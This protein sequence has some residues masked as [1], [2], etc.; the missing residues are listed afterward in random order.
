MSLIGLAA[1]FVVFK[2]QGID[3]EASTAFSEIK[4]RIVNWSPT[5]IF[6]SKVESKLL[7][8]DKGKELFKK[9]EEWRD[10]SIPLSDGENLRRIA[11]ALLSDESFKSLVL[12]EQT[13]RD[14]HNAYVD[15]A[16]SPFLW[17]VSLCIYS[18]ILLAISLFIHKSYLT[19]ELVFIVIT[20]ILQCVV[21]W[22]IFK[23]AMF[24]L[25]RK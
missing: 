10:H 17:T 23:F 12:K 22:K 5:I 8:I 4:Q 1:V 16:I 25:V 15:Q 3:Q 9:L 11:I 20:V 6:P 2:L 7:G 19:L 24:S 13:L 21:Y 14:L 18:A